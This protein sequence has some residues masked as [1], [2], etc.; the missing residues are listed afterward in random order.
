MTSEGRREHREEEESNRRFEILNFRERGSKNPHFWLAPRMVHPH[1][2]L[3]DPPRSGAVG[4][5]GQRFYTADLTWAPAHVSPTHRCP[6]DWRSGQA[7]G[8]V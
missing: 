7:V 2:N 8:Y 6:F 5:P 4:P 3:R 1:R